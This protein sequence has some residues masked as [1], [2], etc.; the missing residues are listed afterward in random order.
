MGQVIERE[1]EQA[2]FDGPRSQARTVGELVNELA[3]EGRTLLRQELALFRT[4]MS[5]KVKE[6]GKQTSYIGAG[7]VLGL[8]GLEILLAAVVLALGLVLPLWAAA[9]I[10]GAVVALGAGTLAL[11]GRAQLRRLDPRPTQTLLSLE[12]NKT[13]ATRLIH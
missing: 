5:D 7:G 12:E 6:A 8:V 11:Y 10:V 2:R 1:Y 13:W 4:E 3:D 9:L